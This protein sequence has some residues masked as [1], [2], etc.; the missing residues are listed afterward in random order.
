MSL[1]KKQLLTTTKSTGPITIR[2]SAA[3]VPQHP[4]YE[5]SLW[6]WVFYLNSYEGGQD[7]GLNTE[8][9]FTH[10][11]DGGGPQLPAPA[12]RLLQLLPLYSGCLRLAS[13]QEGDYPGIAR[14]GL[15]RFPA[16]R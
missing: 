4:E 10:A 6:R 16:K 14:R 2:R 9:L 8:Y 11:R 12:R 7:Y 13:V 3:A 15:P 5:A 1:T